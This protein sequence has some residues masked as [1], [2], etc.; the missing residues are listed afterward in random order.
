LRFGAVDLPASVGGQA[1]TVSPPGPT[2]GTVVVVPGIHGL[3]SHILEVGD[4][5]AANGFTAVVADWWCTA[6]RRGEL[7]APADT[8]R[9]V[10]ALDD[11][12][13]ADGLVAVAEQLAGD[14]PVSLV[15]YCV[16]GTLAL[17]ASGRTDALAATVAYY[18]VLRNRGPLA[19]K[20]PDPIEQVGAVRCPVL[21]H[22]GTAD[23]WCPTEDVD[24]LED[25]LAKTGGAHEVY[26]YPG[27]GHA[28]EE[29]GRPGYRPVAAAEAARRSLVFLD[30]WGR[31]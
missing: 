5:L 8:G 11:D 10:A 31:S 22:Y 15:G 25:V 24:E 18:G 19:D 23:G 16:G 6:A 9:A 3:T 13:I 2:S 17:L 21:A 30:H 4:R 29:T 7:R 26:R 20:G 1:T 14:R 27:A 12:A 28:F